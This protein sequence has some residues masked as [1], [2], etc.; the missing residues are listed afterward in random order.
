M[1]RF[2]IGLIK[3]DEFGRVHC[4]CHGLTADHSLFE[5]QIDFHT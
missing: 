2:I 3:S 4:F 1:V 5:K